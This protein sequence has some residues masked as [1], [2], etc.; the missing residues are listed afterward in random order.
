[1]YHKNLIVIYKG[2]GKLAESVAFN[3]EKGGAKC[4][5]V[6]DIDAYVYEPKGLSI[7]VSFNGNMN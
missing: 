4:I 1:M 6:K 7:A 3:L 5:G 2:L